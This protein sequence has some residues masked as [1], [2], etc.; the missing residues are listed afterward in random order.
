MKRLEQYRAACE[1]RRLAKRTIQTYCRWVEEFLRF[2][3]DRTGQ[4]I[5]PREMSEKEVEAFLTHGQTKGTQF[6][7]LSGRRM[8]GT[9]KED[10]AANP[11]DVGAFGSAAVVVDAQDFDHTVI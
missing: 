5:H 8:A 7:D 9:M 4:W 11:A 3:H 10:E 6:I 1:V 2:H